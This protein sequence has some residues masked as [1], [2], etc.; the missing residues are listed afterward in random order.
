MFH[1]YFAKY[2][3]GATTVGAKRSLWT[4]ASKKPAIQQKKPTE[5]ENYSNRVAEE[6]QPI[7]ELLE[8]TYTCVACDAKYTG[9]SNIGT[10]RC[11]A[12]SGR[13]GARGIWDCCGRDRFAAGCK[14]ADHTSQVKRLEEHDINLEVPL[15]IF[16][17]FDVPRERI[18]IIKH[19]DPRLMKVIVRRME[20]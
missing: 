6:C 15:W 19:S 8:K 11:K 9:I 10:W 14:R 4:I 5:A 3:T 18:T 7:L 12:H 1:S 13:V 20:I 2:D 16:D 17:R